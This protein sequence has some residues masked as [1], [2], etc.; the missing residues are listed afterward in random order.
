MSLYKILEKKGV[1]VEAYSRL[2]KHGTKI[3]RE[4]VVRRQYQDMQE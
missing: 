2:P 4:A 3:K 1:V